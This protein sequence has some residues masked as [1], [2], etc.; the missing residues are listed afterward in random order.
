VHVK[1]NPP[2]GKKIDYIIA[3]GAE[4][5]GYLTTDEAAIRAK[6][7]PIVNGVC[8]LMHLTGVKNGV[9]ALEDNKCVIHDPS[10]KAIDLVKTL[11]DAIKESRFPTQIQV[12]ICETQYPEGG[13]K[14]LIEAVTGREVPPPP[15]LPADAGCIVQNVATI[16]AVS[17]AFEVWD[18]EKNTWS[19]HGRPLIKRGLTVSGGACGNPRNIVAPIGTLI[20]DLPPEYF[21]IN[22]DKLQ[23]IIFGGPM[24]GVAVSKPDIPIQK[25]TSGILFL[26]AEETYSTE[27]GACIRCGRCAKYCPMGLY[28]VL[29]NEALNAEDMEWAEQNG[30]MDCIECGSCTF[31]CP[32]RIKLTQRFRVG[33]FKLR[34]IIAARVAAVQAK[35]AAKE[36][37]TK[38]EAENKEKKSV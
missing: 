25:N 24:M 22:E 16:I 11:E 32:A 20:S 6:A 5:E 17:E 34:N 1:L 18:I 36:A 33:K 26:T 30:V 7:K 2:P 13:E 19:E 31:N 4:C 37:E 10:G 12:T 3:N 21:S 29:M 28:P 27:E 14:M 35:V 38:K 15:A 23:K 8:I 9:I